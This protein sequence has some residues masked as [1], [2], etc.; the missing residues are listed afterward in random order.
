ME[1]EYVMHVNQMS[2]ETY[3]TDPDGK[4]YCRK[5][6]KV[7]INTMQDCYNCDYFLGADRGDVVLCEWE[8]VAVPHSVR[9]VYYGKA[10]EEYKRV[11][12]LIKSGVLK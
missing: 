10:D 11:S 8:D 7:M 2:R 6:H 4:V 9:H 1:L 5:N 3:P 12:E